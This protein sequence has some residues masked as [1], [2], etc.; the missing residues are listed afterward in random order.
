MILLLLAALLLA[1]YWPMLVITARFLTFGDDM[2]HGLFAPLVTM[3]LIWQ[4]RHLFVRPETGPS[5]WSIPALLAAALIGV[6]ATLA[7]SSTISRFAF[8]IS[9]A[10]CLL[11]IG[12]WKMLRTFSFPLTL[13]LFTFPIPAV[14]Y[15]ELTLPL[16]LLASALSERVFE[17][18]G[19]GVLRDGNILQLAHMKLSVVEACSGL[20]SLVTLTFFSL[21][22]VYFFEQSWL[23]RAVI[24][25]MA[26]PAAIAVNVFRI[27]MTGILGKYNPE[28]TH[29]TYHDMLGWSGFFIGFF[30]V[31]L[32]HKTLEATL[33]KSRRG[34]AA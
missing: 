30:L 34:G 20:R 24:T 21:V 1:A 12:G 18:L 5:I 23:R 32:G 22:Y 26:I 17:M 10:G 28:Y 16:Q 25:L 7:N 6:S 27:T 29:G 11:L 14:L 3:Y 31:W 8:L 13:L 33:W 2:A 15:G 4:Q 19:Y 9:L